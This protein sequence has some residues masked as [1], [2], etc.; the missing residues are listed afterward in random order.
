MAES[1]DPYTESAARGLKGVIARSAAS[2][3]GTTRA[4]F[5]RKR[6]RANYSLARTV[7][8]RFQRRG[9]S[10]PQNDPLCG[11]SCSAQDDRT[12]GLALVRVVLTYD[13]PFAPANPGRLFP[14]PP[15]RKKLPIDRH[16]S[17]LLSY[18]QGVLPGSDLKENAGL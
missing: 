15:Y 6:A 8:G 7:W 17:E 5:G 3:V 2:G 1:K 10:T 18:P 14:E 12:P 13:G 11:S 9:P 4:D 16:D